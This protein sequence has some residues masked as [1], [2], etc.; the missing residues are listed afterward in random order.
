MDRSDAIIDAHAVSMFLINR[1]QLA[2][3]KPKWTVA[4]PVLSEM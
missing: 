3:R 1:Y 4:N 2:A